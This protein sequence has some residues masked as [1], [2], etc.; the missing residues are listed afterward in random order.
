M[1]DSY[2]PAGSPSHG[3]PA[4][5]V[6]GKLRRPHG[7]RGEMQM[8]VYTDFPERL[9][10][11]V[12]LYIGEAHLPLQL[13]SC[14]AHG[15]LLLVT[16]PEYTTPEAVGMLRNQLVFVPAADRPPLAPGEY[17]HHQ[18]VG[19]QVMTDEGRLL[20]VVQEILDYPAQDVYV[21][22]T[23]QGREVLL[24]GNKETILDVDLEQGV[25]RVHLIPGLV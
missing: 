2:Q 23:L 25:L 17:Y 14:R 6:I 24:P 21:V 5:L 16:F 11:G 19:L 20:G 4:F 13:Q 3:E 9:Q 7:V 10:P 1:T 12:T 18:L 15:A 22:R 8:E